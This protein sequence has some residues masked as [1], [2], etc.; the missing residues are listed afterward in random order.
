MLHAVS[1]ALADSINVLLIGV[2]FAVGV[3]HPKPARYGKIA[4]V[5]VLGDWLGVLLLS[6]V[7]MLLFDSINEVVHTVL[8]SPALG[9]LLIALGVLSLVVAWRGGGDS[10]VMVARLAKPLQKAGLST[11]TSGMVLGLV[12]SATS[13]P[14]FVGLGYLSTGGFSL[15]VRYL[16]LF[17]YATLALSLP[18]LLGVMIGVV[19]KFPNSVLG[20][21]I[22]SLRTQE[23][24]VTRYAGYVIAVLLIGLGALNLAM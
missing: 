23:E 2:L 15:E 9:L 10:S 13:L 7:T 5:L 14:F 19:L 17:A 4:A 18:M 22:A 8:E 6:A 12:Q 1:F 20:R 24:S 21:G 16:G 3:M 11:F